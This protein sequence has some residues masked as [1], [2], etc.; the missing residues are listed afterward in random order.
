MEQASRQIIQIAAI[1]AT[2]THNVGVLALCQDGTLWDNYADPDNNTWDGW[3]QLPSIPEGTL[4]Y[5]G[6]AQ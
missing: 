3:H 1:P 5:E 6:G 2:E 4:T